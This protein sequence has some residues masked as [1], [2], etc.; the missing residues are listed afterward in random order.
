MENDRRDRKNVDEGRQGEHCVVH[1]HNDHIYCLYDHYTKN[2][3][4]GMEASDDMDI[5]DGR[6]RGDSFDITLKPRTTLEYFSTIF[7]CDSLYG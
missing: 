7:S 2:E 1:N 5:V 4:S 3:A 6:Y